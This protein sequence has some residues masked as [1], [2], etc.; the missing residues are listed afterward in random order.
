LSRPDLSFETPKKAETSG[1]AAPEKETPFTKAKKRK[2]PT[3]AAK[4]GEI[5]GIDRQNSAVDK[6]PFFTPKA[7]DTPSNATRAFTLTTPTQRF[8]EKLRI[9][10][11]PLSA[12]NLFPIPATNNSEPTTEGLEASP[13]QDRAKRKAESEFETDSSLT[14][15]VLNLLRSDNIVL[16]PSTEIQIRHEIDL[17]VDIGKAKIQ[18]YEETI[19]KLHERVDELERMILILTE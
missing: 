7:P 9:G 16:K 10:V 2:A 6:D 8:A 15:T 1:Q 19:S 18:R 4:E 11:S 17:V 13:M 3:D 12:P 5:D 14:S